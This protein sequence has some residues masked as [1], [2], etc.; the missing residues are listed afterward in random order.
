MNIQI[1]KLHESATIP[2]IQNGVSE[3]MSVGAGMDVNPDGSA[4]FVYKTGLSINIPEGYIGLV[5][6]HENLSTKSFGSTNSVTILKPGDKSELLCRF[7]LNT[8][9]IPHMYV[10]GEPIAKLTIVPVLDY[11]FEIVEVA[12]EQS[13]A[14][15]T[16]S[17]DTNEVI[18]ED[19]P[20]LDSNEHK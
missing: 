11:S 6:P 12:N 5:T 17:N 1:S 15:E 2:A 14:G 16:V 4:T 13:T 10:E 18:T 9:S 8:T 19:K 7:K 20:E 3:I